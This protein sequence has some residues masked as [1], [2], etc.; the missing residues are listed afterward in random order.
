MLA[1]AKPNP[2]DL[3]SISANG[4]SATV[5][6]F[7]LDEEVGD[8]WF[9][10]MIGSQ[11][12]VR[13]IAA[14]L[15]KQPPDIAYICEGADGTPMGLNSHSCRVPPQTVGSW[16]TK[17]TKLPS[18]GAYHNL[19]YTKQAEFNNPLLT[20]L[21][22]AKS[23]DEAPQLHHKFLD[24]RSPLPI[25]SQWTDWLWKRGLEAKEITPLKSIGVAAYKCTPFTRTLR[26]AIKDSVISGELTIAEEANL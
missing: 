8:L 7:A 5:D 19:T 17:T 20:F 15:L 24:K 21:L 22:L 12:A 14:A 3:Y 16:T 25:H 11:T 1:T 4:F 23:E 26:R 6:A 2:E 18:S 13:A 9:V 10:S